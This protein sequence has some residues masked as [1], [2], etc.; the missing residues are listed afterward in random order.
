MRYPCLVDKR[1]CKTEIR[2]EIDPGGVD[3]YGK[4]LSPVIYVGK[5]NYQ[6]RAKTVLTAEKKLVEV[7]G[8]ALFPGDIAPALAVI[9]GG[10]VTVF[11]VERRIALGTKARN[12]D[13][14]VNYTGLE[15][16]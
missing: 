4:P 10:S 9:S 2:V 7:T 16:I 12:P 13:G 8:T 1:Q 6:D 11:G 14:T 5:C 15:L 3:K